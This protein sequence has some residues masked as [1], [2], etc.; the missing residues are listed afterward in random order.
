MLASAGV[1]N[2]AAAERVKNQYEKQ[3]LNN[4]TV[5]GKEKKK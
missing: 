4:V 5:H 3:E 2:K 1:S